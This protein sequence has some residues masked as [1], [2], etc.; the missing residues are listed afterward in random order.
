MPR[1]NRPHAFPTLFVALV[2]TLILTPAPAESAPAKP[3]QPP[4]QHPSISIEEP[5]TDSEAE[6][7]D[8][9]EDADSD[10]SWRVDSAPGPTREIPIRVEEGTWMSVDVSP[11]GETIAF[12][13]LGD[14]YEM[15]IGGGRVKKITSGVSWD[16]QPRYSPDGTKLAFT[17]DRGGGDNIWVMK[18]MEMTAEP[19]VPRGQVSEANPAATQERSADVLGGSDDSESG[20]HHENDVPDP[21]SIPGMFTGW[22]APSA[23]T[24]E[25]FRLVNSPAWTPD[26]QYIA[27][28]KHFT[29]RRSLGAGEIWLYHW[30][31]GGGLQMVEKP[32]EQKDLGEPAF[33]PDGRYLYYSQDTTSGSTF[34]YNKDPNKEIYT[35]SR[36]DRIEGRTER[37]LTGPGG[38]VRPTPSPDGKLLAFIKRVRA[39]S[40]LYLHDVETGDEWPIYDGL[41]RDMQET[42]AIHGVYPTIAWT[43][44]SGSI[45]F[46]AE[47]TIQRISVRDQVVTEIPFSIDDT[48]T[49]YERVLS[50]QTAWEESLDVKMLRWVQVSPHG[51]KV[52][53]QALG[54]VWVKD[55]PDGLPRRLT[56]Q[57]DHFEYYPSWSPD[58]EQIVYVTWHD[59]EL[60]SVRM[61]EVGGGPS[62]GIAKVITEEPGHYIEPQVS[63]DGNT[64]VFRKVQGG[65]LRSPTWSKDPGI[66]AAT[67]AETWLVTREGYAP[68][69]GPT[70]SPGSDTEDGFA[71]LFFTQR[72]EKDKRLLKSIDLDGS[73][74]RTHLSSEAATEFHLSPDG[75][76]LAFRERFNVFLA[77]W[78]ATG[79]TVDI[80]PK[81]SSIPVVK[82][83]ADSGAYLHWSGDSQKLHWALGPELFTRDLTDSFK[84][85]AS[86]PDTMPESPEM[87]SGTYIG[88]SRKADVP[89]GTIAFTG[90]RVVTMN[91][92]NSEEVIEDGTVVVEG[93]RIKAVGAASSV[94]IPADA[95]VV[96]ATGKTVIPGIVDIHYHGGAGAEQIIPQ[97]NW[98]HYA[99]LAF[100]VTTTH[101]PSNDTAEVFAAAEMGR[102]GAIVAP[103]VF[104]TGTILYGASGSF[105]AEIDSLDD[106]RFHLKRLKAV[107]SFSVKSYNQPRRDQRQ[108]VLTA[109]RELGLLVYP[110]GGSTFMHNL[111]QVLDGHTTI[112]HSIPVANVYD[113]VKQLWGEAKVGYTPTLVVGYGGLW[114][115]EYWYAKTNVWENERLLSFVPRETVDRRSRRRGI[116]PADEWGH[117]NNARV[118]KALADAGVDILIGAH[119]QREGLGSHWEIWMLVQGGMTPHQAIRAATIEGARYIGMDSDLGSLEPGKLADLVVIDGNPLEDIRQSEN[120]THTMVNGRLYD[121]ATMNEIGNREKARDKLWF[122]LEAYEAGR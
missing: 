97:Q 80:G 30:T 86:D 95:H 74:E 27:A 116:V 110:E 72:G 105:K 73:D 75:E 87:G 26:S 104:S 47:G 6:D 13:L 90:A 18:R 93:N 85:L 100:G 119:G 39:K 57:T 51:S 62:G 2:A 89:E 65:W 59:R 17:S 14:L 96:D 98:Y 38:A 102:A 49:I 11:D 22:S 112:E 29:S 92:A 69:F 12:D 52:A 109:A 7:T 9:S 46:W 66:Y 78:V 43:P 83:N 19:T 81:T 71:R 79:K 44:D 120:V 76:W 40:V 28:R 94:A 103:R 20:G 82:V 4:W 35:V 70:G 113:D 31:G 53:Y 68:F 64:V 10:S 115:E 15:P 99:G 67:F 42:W 33:S 108:Q 121:A 122:E 45:V 117:F 32:N 50:A 60:G 37:Y 41:E 24:E 48:R 3:S 58:G 34:Q 88:F 1:S 5:P 61:M 55:L 114:G 21:N 91:S 118:C 25:A 63:P 84:F 8:T 107:G 101:D 16:M 23:V 36:L 54:Y 77:P 111:T 56:S 106:A